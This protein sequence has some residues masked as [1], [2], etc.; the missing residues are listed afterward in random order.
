[1]AN[2]NIPAGK[3]IETS[4]LCVKRSSTGLPAKVWDYVVGT[5]AKKD[6]CIDEGVTF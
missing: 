3:K 4:D 1:M 5:I 6:Y 2:K